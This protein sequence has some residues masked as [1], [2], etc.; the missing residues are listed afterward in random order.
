MAGDGARARRRRH[1]VPRR[2]PDHT[3]G[4][5]VCARGMVRDALARR[6]ARTGPVRRRA[7]GVRGVPSR[8]GGGTG[9]VARVPARPHDTVGRRRSGRVGRS[10]GLDRCRTRARAPPSPRNHAWASR[11]VRR[12]RSSTATSVATCCSPTRAAFRLRSSTSRRTTARVR[13]RTRSSSPTPSPG[14]TRRSAFAERF[15][16][17]AE[18]GAEL[19]ARALVFRLVAAIELWGAESAR[20][21]AEVQAYEPLVTLLDLP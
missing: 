9:A 21:A 8:T 6:R 4:R 14:T 19:L 3:P 5:N 2:R 7:R 11:A 20:V 16:A 17:T 18:S 15:V 12:R 13:S 1:R 10:P